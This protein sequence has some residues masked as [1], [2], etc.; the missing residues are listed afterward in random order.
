MEGKIMATMVVR[1][2]E[3]DNPLAPRGE[4]VGHYSEDEVMVRWDN[5]PGLS[6]EYQDE[7]TPVGETARAAEHEA[8]G[9]EHRAW[10]AGPGAHRD[11][12]NR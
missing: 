9:A 8:G 12:G 6:C 2:H 5:Q 11:G 3:A 10:C 1:L 4:V 7:L